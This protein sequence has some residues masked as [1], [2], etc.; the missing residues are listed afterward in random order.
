MSVR[1]VYT[2]HTKH[3]TDYDINSHTYIWQKGFSII[4]LCDRCMN[5][6]V[7]NPSWHIFI[8]TPVTGIL[9]MQVR[10]KGIS[11]KLHRRTQ[12][13][14]RFNSV[15]IR[16]YVH[17]KCY[18]AIFVK[19]SFSR[20]SGKYSHSDFTNRNKNKTKR[21]KRNAMEPTQHFLE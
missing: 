15:P 19:P 17:Q 3:L 5:I 11:R 14:N 20:S 16:V 4:N 6:P 21:R 18:T 10:K 2:I 13:L 9:I 8:L 7:D 1:R 12:Q